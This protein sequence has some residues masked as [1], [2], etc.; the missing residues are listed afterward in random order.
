MKEEEKK[1]KEKIPHMC[2]SLGHRPLWRRCPKKRIERN[3]LLKLHMVRSTRCSIT[4]HIVNVIHVYES[5][6]IAS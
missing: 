1:K 6:L 5:P 2:E 4:G 3:R